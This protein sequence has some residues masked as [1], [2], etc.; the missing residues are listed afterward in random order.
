MVK[1]E[2]NKKKSFVNFIHIF[3]LPWCCIFPIA[4]AFFGLAGG[5]LGTFLSRFTPFFLI[6]SITLISYANYNVWF[7]KFRSVQHR[8]WVVLITILTILAWLWS[9]TFVMKW[10]SF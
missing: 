6:I 8:I 4:V 5:T 2:K 9:I 7:G 10:I 3:A 1:E